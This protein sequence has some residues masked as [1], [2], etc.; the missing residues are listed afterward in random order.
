MELTMNTYTKPFAHKPD[1]PS[2]DSFLSTYRAKH[3]TESVQVTASNALWPLKAAKA[4]TA[5]LAAQNPL[6]RRANRS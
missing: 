4:W 2:L 3:G 1:H 5:H 6:K